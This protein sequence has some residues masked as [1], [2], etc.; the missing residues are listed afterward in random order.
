MMKSQGMMKRPK[1]GSGR[2]RPVLEEESDRGFDSL[3]AVEEPA[4]IE[5][6]NA[7]AKKY[8]APSSASVDADVHDDPDPGAGVHP[9]A[10]I[11]RLGVG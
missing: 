5:Q 10:T 6:L 1:T 11:Q 2:V 9:A 4:A 7:R 3:G 8:E